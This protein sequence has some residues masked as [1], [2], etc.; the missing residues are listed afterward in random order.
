LR[1]WELNPPR[2]AY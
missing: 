2:T 1:E